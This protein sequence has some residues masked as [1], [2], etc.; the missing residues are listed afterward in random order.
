MR[1]LLTLDVASNELCQEIN[2]DKYRTHFLPKKYQ[3]GLAAVI[4]IAVMVQ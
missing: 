2:L 1:H 4:N 3:N